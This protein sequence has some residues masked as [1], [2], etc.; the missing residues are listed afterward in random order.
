MRF[1]ILI[2][3]AMSVSQLII[4]DFSENAS[5]DNWRI[6]DDVV[7]G[8]RSDGKFAL[9]EEGHAEFYGDVSLENNGGFSS[10]R[11]QTE[12]INIDGYSHYKIRLKGDGK[13]YQ[14]RC[15][16]SQNQ[17]HSYIYEFET[18]GDWQTVTIGFDTMEATF[19]GRRLNIPNFDGDG[20]SEIAFLIGN[21]KE[22]S[23]KLLIDKI[24]VE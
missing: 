11:Y 13:V 4:F 17:R 16:S 15:K 12:S 19:R 21:K 2:L 24:W 18:T 7:M 6:V 14:F 5:L 10:V 9:N 1:F 22:Q 20:V 8:G 3:L 23:F